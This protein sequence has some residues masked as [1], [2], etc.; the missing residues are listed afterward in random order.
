MPNRA[1]ALVSR[2]QRRRLLDAEAQAR[3][4]GSWPVW[5]SDPISYGAAGYGWAAEFS[6]V[7]HNGVFAVLERAMPDGVRH[8][9][10]SSLSG[11]RPTWWEAQRIKDELAG[12]EATAVEVYPPRDEVVDEADMFHLWVLTAPLP[13]G[14]SAHRAADKREAER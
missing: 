7:H 8:L 3:K 4:S 1:L 12:V 9:G 5:R 2:A 6:T 10:I 11:V 13:F 14:L